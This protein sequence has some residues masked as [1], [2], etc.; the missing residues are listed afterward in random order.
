MGANGTNITFNDHCK[1]AKSTRTLVSANGT[2]TTSKEHHKLP[3]STRRL[4][5]TNN[6]S[7]AKSQADQIYMDIGGC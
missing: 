5:S 2:N 6:T 3:R 7:K 4:K 1:L